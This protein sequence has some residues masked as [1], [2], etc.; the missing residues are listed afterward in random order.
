MNRQ[1]II[2]FVVIFILVVI[3]MFVLANMD[4]NENP[5]DATSNTEEDI[6]PT[7]DRDVVMPEQRKINAKH[8]H[9][10]GV[11]TFVGEVTLPTPCDL[12][13]AQTVV[14]ESDPEQVRI[15]FKTINTAEMCAQVLT[16]QR[17]SAEATASKAANISA[18][19]NGE[20]IEI[21]LIPAEPNETPEEFE[22][23]YKG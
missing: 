22:L 17:F 2:I 8:F 9:I 18:T 16:N 11:H 12:L 14:M 13:E 1:T 7:D 19:F 20:P 4:K 3:G 10:D 15:D 23:Y 6:S 21:N 5:E